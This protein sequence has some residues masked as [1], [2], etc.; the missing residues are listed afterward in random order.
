[1]TAYTLT[2]DLCCA[3]VLIWLVAVNVGAICGLV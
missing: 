1:M 2:A 3:A